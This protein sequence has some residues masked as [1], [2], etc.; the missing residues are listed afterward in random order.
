MRVSHLR[1]DRIGH[2]VAVGERVDV[3]GEGVDSGVRV[4][5]HHTGGDHGVVEVD[6]DGARGRR[7]LGADL[8]AR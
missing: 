6:D 8:V 3:A 7:D 5:I 2:L 4:Q 1:E